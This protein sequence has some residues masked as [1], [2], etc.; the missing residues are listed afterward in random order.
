[1]LWTLNVVTSCDL[2]WSHWQYQSYD[3]VDLVVL[4]FFI[5]FLLFFIQDHNVGHAQKLLVNYYWLLPYL[6]QL[7]GFHI[8]SFFS[9]RNIFKLVTKLVPKT[10]DFYRRRSTKEHVKHNLLLG[11]RTRMFLKQRVK[12]VRPL[13]VK[14]VWA[15]WVAVFLGFIRKEFLFWQ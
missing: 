14:H 7:V 10:L 13:C 3:L 11:C 15:L 2:S 8:I 12:Y 4:L 9:H 5:P 1:M 6:I